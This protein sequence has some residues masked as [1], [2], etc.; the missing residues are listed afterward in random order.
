MKYDWYL[1]LI[2]ILHDAY[3]RLHLKA[4]TGV[5]L[6]WFS[7]MTGKSVRSVL[8]WVQDESYEPLLAMGFDVLQSFEE[9]TNSSE[10]VSLFLLSCI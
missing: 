1:R 10:H 4:W 5:E 9:I 8:S 2:Q 3:P 7:R 6:D